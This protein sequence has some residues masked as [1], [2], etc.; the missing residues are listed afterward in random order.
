M[1]RKILVALDNSDLAHKVMLQALEL[2]KVYQAQIFAVSVIN[3]SALSEIDNVSSG[4]GTTEEIYNWTNS[5]QEVLDK[6][7]ELAGEF[8]IEHYEAMLSGTPAEEILKYAEENNIDLIV[9]GHIGKTGAA[10]FVLGSV[11]Q[12]VST[13]SKCTVVIVK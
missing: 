5:F 3:Y 7:R 4:A 1:I 6:C 11:S 8:G 13:H 12:K 9:M 10:G 2:A